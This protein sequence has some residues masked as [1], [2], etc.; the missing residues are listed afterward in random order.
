[1][2]FLSRRRAPRFW[3]QDMSL[4]QPLPPNP[5]LAPCIRFQ[6]LENL[7][8]LVKL[9]LKGLDL[10][11]QQLSAMQ[12]GI[13]ASLQGPDRIDRILKVQLLFACGPTPALGPA[14]VHRRTSRGSSSG[15]GARLREGKAP[16]E[17]AGD[18]SRDDAQHRSGVVAPRIVSRQGLEDGPLG[19]GEEAGDGCDGTRFEGG[20][21]VV[22]CALGDLADALFEV[23]VFLLR[24]GR[25]LLCWG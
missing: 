12:Q 15:G 21:F 8:I 16:C 23:S 9:L 18:A 17:A 3:H 5:R 24:R 7:V 2:W 25:F 19:E 10:G 1:M 22:D 13:Q 20:P 11:P 14:R 4:S 6:L